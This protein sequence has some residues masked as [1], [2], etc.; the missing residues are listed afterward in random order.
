MFGW[1]GVDPHT[2]FE[3]DIQDKIGYPRGAK[4]I[5]MYVVRKSL[6]DRGGRLHLHRLR[7]R[8]TL[9]DEKDM[10]EHAKQEQVIDASTYTIC[11]IPTASLRHSITIRLYQTHAVKAPGKRFMFSSNLP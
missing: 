3:R 10:H 4:L 5:G 9:Q 1:L 11:E 7:S 6:R 8:D 2:L